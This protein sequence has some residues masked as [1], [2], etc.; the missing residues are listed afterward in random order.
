MRPLYMT[1]SVKPEPPQAPVVIGYVVVL[2]ASRNW[3]T[4]SDLMDDETAQHEAAVW[5]RKG[6]AVKVCPVIEEDR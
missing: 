5:R 3:L 2:T 4:N 6:Y 1:R